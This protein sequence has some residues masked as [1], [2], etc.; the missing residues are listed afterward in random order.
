MIRIRFLGFAFWHL[1]FRTPWFCGG[2][3]SAFFQPCNQ[4]RLEPAKASGWR[5]AESELVLKQRRSGVAD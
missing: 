3:V 1:S 2:S 4:H 5:L